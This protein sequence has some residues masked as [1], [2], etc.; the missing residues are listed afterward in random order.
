MTK[1]KMLPDAGFR[2]SSFVVLSSFVIGHSSLEFDG[3]IHSPALRAARAVHVRVVGIDISATPAPEDV[4]LGSRR[5]KSPP[6]QLAVNSQAGDPAEQDHYV[7]Q[8]QVRNR[9]TSG[10][11]NDQ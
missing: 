6:A 3:L 7:S 11:T 10:M 1:G 9:H 8:D 2:T 4:V 5:L